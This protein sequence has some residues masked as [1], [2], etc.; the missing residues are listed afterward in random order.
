M[1]SP[2][3]L[4]FRS[5]RYHRRIHCA[6]AMAVVVATAILT[7]ALIVGDSMR[8]SLRHLLLDRLGHIDHAFV[9]EHFFRDHLA[10]ELAEDTTFTAHFESAQPA[11]FLR[12]TAER[13]D[14]GESGIARLRANKVLI[15]GLDANYSQLGQGGPQAFPGLNEVVLNEPLARELDAKLGDPIVLRLPRQNLIPGDSPFGR[16]TETVRS[17]ARLK[18]VEIIPA[19]GL[20]RFGLRPTQHVPR[21]AFVARS[22]LQNAL[23]QPGRANAILITSRQPADAM[24]TEILRGAL[25][26]VL[27]DYGMSIERE[28]LTFQESPQAS[29]DVIFDYYNVFTNRMMFLPA[30]DVAIENVLA[31][32]HSQAALTYLANSIGRGPLPYRV[33]EKVALLQ[34]GGQSLSSLVLSAL[35]AELSR[36]DIPYSTI[37][38][39]DSGFPLGPVSTTSGGAI[40]N[41]LED[42]IVLNRWAADVLQVGPGEMVNVTYFAPESTHG[43][44]VEH[45]ATFRVRTIVELTQPAEPYNGEQPPAYDQRPTLANDPWLTP[46]VKGF[47]DKKSVEDW[48]PPFPFERQRIRDVDELY[49]D[50]Y[51]ATPKAFVSLSTGQDLWGTARFGRTTSYR[52]PHR[53]GLSVEKV[54]GKILNQFV[55][56][57][58]QPGFRL[59]PLRRQGIEASRGTTSFSGLFLGFSF[60]LI[61]AALMLVAL[62]FRL[63]IHQRAG[64]VGVLVAVGWTRP[65]IIK[66]YALEGLLVAA[67]G[68]V[69][70]VVAGIGY[71]ALM[72]LGLSTW[73]VDA[74]TTPFVE[75][76][77]I[78]LTSL[79]LGLF[80]GMVATF[81]A[82]ILTFRRLQQTVVRNLLAGVWEEFATGA[83]P[84]GNWRTYWA[85]GLLLLA[86]GLAVLGT[87]LGGEAQ[88]GAFFGCGGSVL[89][90]SLLSTSWWL[91]RGVEGFEKQTVHL[92]LV[93]LARRNI[94]R[95]PSRSVL[96]I[97]LIASA[98]FLIVA[99]SCFRV[100]SS[101]QG[102][103]G[104]DLIAES[105]QPIYHDLNTKQGRDALGIIGQDTTF[106]GGQEAGNQVA[107]FRV[108]GGDDASCLNLFRPNQPRVL[109][110]PVRLFEDSVGMHDFLWAEIFSPTDAERRNP[111]LLLKK[112]F[113]DGAVPVILDK[114]TA[115]Y[116]MH[117]FSIRGAGATF[118]INYDGGQSVRYRI[119]ALLA[120]SIFQ[121]SMLISEE[122]FEDLFPHVGG[123][124]LFLIQTRPDRLTVDSV[125]ENG[126][127]QR[128]SKLTHASQNHSGQER[129]VGES[130]QLSAMLENRLGDQGLDV[131][132]TQDVLNGLLAVQNT[133]LETFQSLGALGLLLGTFGLA[134]VQVRSV[135]ERQGE[136]ALMRAMGFRP[137]RLAWIV[138][139]EN[140]WLL[141]TGLG[142]GIF[143]AMVAVFPHWLSGGA[144]VPVASLSKLLLTVLVVGIVS[145]GIAVRATLRTGMVP[146]LRS[147]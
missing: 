37:T 83:V 139:L 143:S 79:C 45:W 15:W 135:T 104:F 50:Y 106:L 7:G 134:T 17:L 1:I 141:L 110:A 63:G 137:A 48:D 32:E 112:R 131:Q 20:G 44:N 73:W 64:E 65:Q 119:V 132:S 100:E 146:A 128:P 87:Q 51:R 41:L 11:I 71:A 9:A 122:Y 82:M 53:S 70:G 147:G 103:G 35:T 102:A 38:A 114:N 127:E 23:E 49:W 5:L 19:E 124:Q 2:S 14:Q 18:V 107:A 123:Y 62:L 16:K 6:V 24:A 47:T 113:D 126:I 138:L 26:P 61:A 77:N 92:S 31:A 4:I 12:V 96:T 90:A 42:E 28:R 145:G 13:T 58:L 25:H 109:G 88:A 133:Y 125:H 36:Q 99:I 108:Q 129:R 33:L 89:V 10:R 3:K 55:R 76:Q 43:A 94:A 98:A 34:P 95:N 80:G 142:M 144:S 8:E 27:E 39:I 140:A 105:D 75:L 117:L 56:D 57:Q 69:L 136:L 74:I 93:G 85:T 68:S 21:I 60:F 111:W 40:E 52:V 78:S 118:E 66:A 81:F 84:A 120:N 115:M 30:V 101:L 86:L 46:E 91:R 130:R 67:I 29:T 121:G 22:I 72:L 97:G 54:E 59:L 116:S